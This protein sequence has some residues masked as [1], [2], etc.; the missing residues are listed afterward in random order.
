MPQF[1]DA[2]DE[3]V[4]A[5]DIVDQWRARREDNL[6]RGIPDSEDRGVQLDFAGHGVLI[7][8][9]ETVQ[10]P[11]PLCLGLGETGN[12]VRLVPCFYE[13]VLATLDEA[14]E[15]GAVILDETMPNNR[16]EIGP[17]TYDGNLERL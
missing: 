2:A 3:N 11:V 1:V 17:C 6:R 13:D 9:K 14:W 5:K 8:A 15:T 7:V 16:W 10:D 4:R 12:K